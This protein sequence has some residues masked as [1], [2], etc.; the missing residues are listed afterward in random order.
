MRWCWEDRKN[1][2]CSQLCWNFLCECCKI[3]WRLKV[4]FTVIV[5]QQMSDVRRAIINH[6]FALLA[7]V[8]S[9]STSSSM[10]V[11]WEG[12]NFILFVHV[13]KFLNFFPFLKAQFI[14]DV[15]LLSF[16][17]YFHQ[18]LI[19][20]GSLFTWRKILNKSK[21]STNCWNKM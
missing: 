8:T 11:R 6:I 21:S 12:T 5:S 15:C 18:S 4:P 7:F 16:A 13:D 10:F 3:C 9:I 20:R 19:H 2:T 1:R 17:F 14:M